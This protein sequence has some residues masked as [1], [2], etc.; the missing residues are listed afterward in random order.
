M[1]LEIV[2]CEFIYPTEEEDW[3]LYTALQEELHVKITVKNTFEE[4]LEVLGY[5]E[6]NGGEKDEDHSPIDPGETHEF[7]LSWKP[8]PGDEGEYH[9]G[10]WDIFPEHVHVY[11]FAPALE[12]F[13]SIEHQGWM[14]NI[15]EAPTI[16]HDLT[17]NVE[18]E[19]STD[20]S[21]G[22][23]S[24]E[25]D[26]EVPVEAVEDVSGWEF[27]HWSG[28]VES[29]D[30]E[31]QVMM[32]EDKSVT[33][34]FVE[35]TEIHDW[36]DLDG[37]RDDLSGIYR[38]K[39]DLDENTDGYGD[40]VGTGDGW[41]SIGDSDNKFTGVFDGQGYTIYD[42][43]A[44][45]DESYVSFIGY[46]DEGGVIKDLNVKNAD[47]K[48]GFIGASGIAGYNDGLIENCSSEGYFEC[49]EDAGAVCGGIPSSTGEVKNCKGEGVVRGE[50]A[51]GG[52]VGV[53][54][55]DVYDSQVVNIEVEA[56]TQNF[57]SIGGLV[58]YLT[59]A[60]SIN[61]SYFHGS[62][63]G[64]ENIGGVAGRIDGDLHDCYAVGTVEGEEKVGGLIGH[65]NVTIGSTEV[66]NSYSIVEVI[67][68]T[69]GSGED[70]GALIGL[71]AGD[72]ENSFANE[73]LTEQTDL[74]GR[75]TGSVSDSGMRDTEEMTHPHTQAKDTFHDYPED[76]WNLDDHGIVEDP[77]GNK[78]YP[79]LQWQEVCPAALPITID[80]DEVEEIT[81]DGE[82]VVGLTVDS[83]EIF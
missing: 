83:E 23:H 16:E 49:E 13:E 34:H 64:E 38:L 53:C 62:V 78:G 75:D 12:S 63:K 35:V 5:I 77:E 46:N 18:G 3:T 36:Y 79:G 82:E 47:M 14:L 4:P 67:D 43:K 40:L 27:S 2:D 31:I 1:P 58:G 55:G 65:C 61:G 57:T 48:G 24:Y 6:F 15:E 17:I 30:K 32:D 42:L 50:Y 74:I 20:P 66:E 68:V 70:I 21:E 7:E 81:I 56:V 10:Y 9:V 28:D 60:G 26:T 33:A 25:E 11:A 39:T 54:S 44:D 73:E 8:E 52:L 45:K 71:N 72:V 69:G 22:T 59:T 37:A 76:I 19:G 29:S 80:G 41:D 51:I